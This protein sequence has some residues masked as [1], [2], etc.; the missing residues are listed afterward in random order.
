MH[1]IL[2]KDRLFNGMIIPENYAF[3]MAGTTAEL[4]EAMRQVMVHTQYF[5][6]YEPAI[7]SYF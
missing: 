5:M 3:F 2:N 4:T 7:V 6:F 1:T